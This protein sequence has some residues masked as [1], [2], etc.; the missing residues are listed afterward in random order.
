SP[1]LPGVGILATDATGP[2]YARWRRGVKSAFTAKGTWGHCDGSDPMPMP[3]SG[4]NFFS[5]APTTNSQPEL[6]KERKAW[7]N[8]DRDVK[9]DIFLSVADDI[10]VEIFEVGPPMPPTAMTAEQMFETLDAHFEQ[11]KFEDYHHIFCHFLNLHIDQYANLEDFNAEFQLTLSDLL[12][13]GHPMSN[14]QACSAYFSKLR[15]TQNPWVSKKLKEWDTCLTEPNLADLMKESPPWVIIRPLTTKGASSV[16]ESIPEESLEDTPALS[17]GEEAASE[18]SETATLSSESTHSRNSSDATQK[19]QE[20]TVHASYED[21]TGLESFPMPLAKLPPNPVPLRLSSK[22]SLSQ[23]N[24]SSLPPLPPVNR[25]L[26][27]LP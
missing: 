12:D 15:C 7:A 17:E 5:P 20:I 14:T 19:S 21:L 1:R 16:P 3:E 23:M 22:K 2:Q 27:P 8:K 11:F 18:K 10:K 6:L 25:P 9:M 13:H 24:M 4:P 26:P